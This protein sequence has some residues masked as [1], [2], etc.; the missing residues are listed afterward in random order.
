MTALTSSIRT[1]QFQLCSMFGYGARLTL[2]KMC[3]PPK[4][5]LPRLHLKILSKLKC[6][7]QWVLYMV[8]VLGHNFIVMTFIS[9]I[10][11]KIKKNLCL[12][13]NLTLKKRGGKKTKSIFR[14]CV[15]SLTGIT[16]MKS[17]KVFG[18]R[19]MMLNKKYDVTCIQLTLPMNKVLKTKRLRYS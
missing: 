12:P 4:K 19:G 15:Y 11:K 7:A 1:T 9:G 3:Y 5:F 18:L 8:Q 14:I 10:L 13:Q 16:P 2:V 17:Q 6:S